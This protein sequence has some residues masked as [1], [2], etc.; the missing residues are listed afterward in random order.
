GSWLGT[1]ASAARVYDVPTAHGSTL[2][3]RFGDWPVHAA[4]TVL[5]VLAAV[6]AARRLRRRAAASE[7]PTAQVSHGR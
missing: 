4:V 6:E 1:S 2:Y 5:V 7:L 3:V